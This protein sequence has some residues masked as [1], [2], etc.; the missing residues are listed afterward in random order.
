M[1][2]VPAVVVMFT[3]V[4]T[5]LGVLMLT[6]K[7][8]LVPSLAIALAIAI[9]GSG[10]ASIIVPVA[11]AVGFDVL[12]DETVPLMINVSVP[13]LILSIV[14]GTN[15]FTLVAPTGIVTVVDVVV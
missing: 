11:C 5:L 2:A 8:A 3:T 1:P 10:V 7:F 15:T 4:G 13:S 6:I 14:V 12:L 9:V